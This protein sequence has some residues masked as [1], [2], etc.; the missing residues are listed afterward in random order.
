MRGQLYDRESRSATRLTGQNVRGL[1][2]LKLEKAIQFMMDHRI[3]ITCLMETWH[4]TPHGCEVQEVGQHL[5]VHHGEKEKTCRRGRNGVAIILSPEARAAW[6]ARGSK[7][8]YN[9]NG[10]LLM[11]LLAVEGGLDLQHYLASRTLLW[12]GHVARMPKSR[13][14]KR[15][16]LSWV[17][18]PRVFGGQE[19]TY[20]RSLERHLQ[21]FDLPTKFT[22]WAT[23]AQDRG[24]W[25]K[26]VT[27]P[28]FA[29]GKPF[30][31]RPR[32]DTRVTPEDTRRIMAQRA[33]EIAERRAAFHSSNDQQQP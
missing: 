24:A 22:E 18:T 16:L 20:G 25:H 10:R 15:F 14:P 13:L 19:M 3:L 1:T 30:V 26:L 17:R 9:G 29:I 8:S 2:P 11:M 5:V 12:A 28:P 23:L 33:A 4:S 6:E 7:I 32:G 31:R 21:Q 27:K